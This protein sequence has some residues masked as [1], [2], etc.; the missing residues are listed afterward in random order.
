[1]WSESEVVASRIGEAKLADSADFIKMDYFW[2][3]EDFIENVKME[4]IAG[5]DFPDNSRLGNERFVILN[6]KAVE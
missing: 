2:M 5:Q 4:L 1:M 3:D 6:E